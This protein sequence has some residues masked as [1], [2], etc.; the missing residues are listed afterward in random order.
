MTNAY[1]VSACHSVRCATAIF[2]LDKC[3]VSKDL[4]TW[5]LEAV[6]SHVWHQ[7]IRY[8]TFHALVC[9]WC[10]R[11][12]SL[13]PGYKYRLCIIMTYTAKDAGWFTGPQTPIRSVAFYVQQS[14][15][16]PIHASARRASISDVIM[17]KQG[18]WVTRLPESHIQSKSLWQFLDCCINIHIIQPKMYCKQAAGWKFLV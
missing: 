4:G 14:T 1:T 17:N 6:D 15:C 16:S 13:R 10:G 9:V 3:R 8:A 11:S 18:R 2:Y 12:G 5:G 7:T